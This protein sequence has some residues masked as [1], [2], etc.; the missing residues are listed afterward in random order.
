MAMK[1]SGS[2]RTQVV[3]M[4]L[5]VFISLRTFPFLVSDR[6]LVHTAETETL[7]STSGLPGSSTLLTVER[8]KLN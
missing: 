8:R 6:R 3:P 7:T 4:L 5:A 2:N 1:S